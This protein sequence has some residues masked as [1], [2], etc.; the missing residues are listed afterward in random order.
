MTARRTGVPDRLVRLADAVLL[1]CFDGLI[2]P[3]WVQ[4]RVAEGM[5]GVCLFAR[6]VESTEQ[7]ASLS[8]ALVSANSDVVIAIDEEAGDV[9]RMD[10]ATGSRFPGAWALG[11]VD[12]TTLTTIIGR[13]VGELLRLAGVSLNLAPSADVAL[14]P[15]NPVIGSRAFGADPE[16]VARHTAAWIHGQQAAGVAACAKHFPGHGDTTT[17]SHHSVAVVS[18]DLATLRRQ[19]LPPFAAAV[20]AGTAAIMSGHLVVPAVD[21]VPA[22]ISFRWLTEV[23]RGELGFTGVIVTDALEMAGIAAVYGIRGAAVRSLIAGAD[24]LC[25]GG[26]TRPESEIDTIR[27]AIVDAVLDGSLPEERLAQA[28]ARSK[29]VGVRAARRTAEVNAEVT[30]KTGVAA[31]DNAST[32]GSRTSQS[33]NIVG[34]HS[35]TVALN[36]TQTAGPLPPLRGPILVLRCLDTPNTAV[37]IVPWGPA[38]VLTLDTDEIVLRNTDH[39]PADS[40]RAAGIVLVVTRD[41]HR[42]PWMV[43]VLGAVR[44]VR[45]DTVLIEMGISGVTDADAPA[46]A[47]FGATRANTR[48]VVE[49]LRGAAVTA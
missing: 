39:V 49:L 9:T 43:R 45:P 6:N 47:S 17:D 32:T 46:I 5:G 8:E 3:E 28:A 48:A 18:G 40:V 36:A 1:P 10:A 35:M 14:N 7:V 29:T 42:S 44:S 27:D 24:L 2:A 33:I 31:V 4:R 11:R 30:A 12:D 13:Q 37:G 21:D 16:L 15:A 34:S 20:A 25:I 38:T 41:R 19:A 22:T 23:L 26:Q